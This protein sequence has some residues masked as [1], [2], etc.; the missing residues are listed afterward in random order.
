MLV[1]TPADNTRVDAASDT[2]RVFSVYRG[3]ADP[4]TRATSGGRGVP[5]RTSD[6]IGPEDRPGAAQACAAGLAGCPTGGRTPRLAL[7]PAPIVLLDGGVSMRWQATPMRDTVA[8]ERI[9]MY[10]LAR[11]G[12]DTVDR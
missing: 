6:L 8:G 1:S 11:V 9:A 5:V 7:R 12:P 2:G 3:V 4:T 10:W